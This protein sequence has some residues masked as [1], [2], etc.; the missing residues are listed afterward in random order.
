MKPNLLHET[1]ISEFDVWLKW[2]HNKLN[3]IILLPTMTKEI[4][5]ESGVGDE[6]HNCTISGKTLFLPG[7]EK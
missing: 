6:P 7:M 4:Y 2:V 3:K 5:V 1:A